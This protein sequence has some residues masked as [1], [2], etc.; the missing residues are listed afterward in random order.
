MYILVSRDALHR[1]Y[2]IA[3]GSAT[4]RPIFS[5]EEDWLSLLAPKIAEDPAKELAISFLGHGLHPRTN[6]RRFGLG[7]LGAD[8]KGLSPLEFAVYLSDKLSVLPDHAKL[9][10]NF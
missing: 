4:G 5:I 1:N 3:E 10:L 8:S 2:A 7:L 9:A 6:D